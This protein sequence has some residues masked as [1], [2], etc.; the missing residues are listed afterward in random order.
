MTSRTTRVPL[1]AAGLLAV[2]ALLLTGCDAAPAERPKAAAAP[3]G[4]E[5]FFAEVAARCA[6][7]GS[8]APASAPAE[9]ELPT[10]PEARKYAENH[11]YRQQ[12]GLSAEGTC[13]GDAHAARIRSALAGKPPRTADELTGLLRGLGYPVGPGDVVDGAGG[14]G[15][16]GPGFALWIPGSG[17]CVEGTSAAPAR[18]EA[19]GPYAEGGCREP[20]GGH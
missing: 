4:P 16:T 11:G 10:D 14:A 19:H 2:G 13:R 12:A 9:Q 8:G 1:T 3:P 18:V 15:G 17:P 20:K 5:V 7:A 6:G